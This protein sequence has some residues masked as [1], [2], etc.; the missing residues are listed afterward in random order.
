[1]SNNAGRPVARPATPPEP[2]NGSKSS[3]GFKGNFPQIWEFLANPRDLGEYHKTGS[4]TLFVDGEKIK[5]CVND[6]PARQSCFVSGDTLME[7]LSTVERGFVEG[8]LRWSAAGYRRRSAPKVYKKTP[9]L[10]A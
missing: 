4:I 3:P 5:L 7:A 1:M 2:S 9:L 8:S 6:R 10:D